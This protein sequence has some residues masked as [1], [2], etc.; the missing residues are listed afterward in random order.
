MKREVVVVGAGVVGVAL[1]H[2]LS[3]RD[4]VTVTVLDQCVQEPL[5]STAFAPGFVGVYNDVPVLTRLARD[6]AA[7][8][9]AAGVGFRRSGGLE[10]ATSDA[11]VAE[12]ESRVES[13]RAKGLRA[14][15][16]G[17]ADLPASVTA[18]V[19]TSNVLAAGHFPDDGSA[20]VQVLTL[21]LKTQAIERGARF[22]PSQRVTGIN[23]HGT[24]AVVTTESGDRF[25]A[26]DIVLAGGIWGPTLA[27]L[28]GLDLPLFPVAHPYVYDSAAT[29][30]DDGPFVRWP[31]H[32]VYSRIHG[33][34]LG[35]GSYDHR[36]VPVE[37]GELASGA[38][39]QW[40][41]DFGPVIESAQRLLRPEV[42][43]APESRVNGVFAMTPD[44]LPFL[45]R[46]TESESV[47]MA[48]AIWVTHAAGAAVMLTEAMF[49]GSELP[50]EL[51]VSRFEGTS[52]D[53]LD[54]RAMRL[55]RDIYANDS[56]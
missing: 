24:G 29:V 11:G 28:V 6:S 10:V 21:G 4:G 44:N 54:E 56:Q 38:G 2:T 51:R 15:L 32:H 53:V 46:L 45:G 37:Q 52:S 9:D 48:Q 14:E 5:G 17:P 40:S 36:P 43:F 30:W 55:Y 41:T 22:L 1:A 13:A 23:P 27:S 50:G 16:L 25:A 26:D 49:E 35:I 18:F 42:R 12:I 33:D 20:D 34:R 3:E 7:V 8:Y 47:W 19:D 39:L 31:E